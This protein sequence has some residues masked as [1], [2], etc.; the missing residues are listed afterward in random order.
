MKKVQYRL[1]FPHNF[2]S[3]SY[4][5]SELVNINLV[6]GAG[7]KPNDRCN[8]ADECRDRSED[9]KLLHERNL[10]TTRAA[11]TK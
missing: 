8:N 6:R 9:T 10:N 4:T 1:I 7:D 5:R 2:L 3:L 11:P